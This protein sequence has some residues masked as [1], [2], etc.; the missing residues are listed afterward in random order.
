MMVMRGVG[1]RRVV[2]VRDFTEFS[3]G[4]FVE[5]VLLLIF[6]VRTEETFFCKH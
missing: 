4:I 6:C 5:H 3:L 2:L 1:C